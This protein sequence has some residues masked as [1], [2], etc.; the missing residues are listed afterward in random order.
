MLK[1]FI[2]AATKGNP[3]LSGAGIVL[4]DAGKQTQISAPLPIMSNHEAEFASLILA[5]EKLIERE[6]NNQSILLYTDSKVVAQTIDKNFT[7]NEDFSPYLH[8]FNLLERKF[9]L[10]VV[11]WIPEAQNKGAD[12]LAR[13][14]LQKALKIGK[15]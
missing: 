10:L 13:Q 9:P 11:Q 2:D 5:L 7:N 8:R 1:V 4:I 6:K 3:G 14:G 15:V 12:N